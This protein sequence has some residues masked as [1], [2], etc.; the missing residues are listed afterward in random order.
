MKTVHNNI[1]RQKALEHMSVVCSCILAIIQCVR[2]VEKVLK[3]KSS[4]SQC[5]LEFRL[6]TRTSKDIKVCTALYWIRGRLRIV[7]VETN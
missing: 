6:I 5:I 4:K 1:S 7:R 3:V 2:F